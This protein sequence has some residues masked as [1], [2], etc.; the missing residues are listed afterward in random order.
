MS[1]STANPLP[2]P[3]LAA[4]VAAVE[5]S[6]V[7]AAADALD[8]TQSAVTKRLHSLERRVGV[9]LL[10]RG[11]FGARPTVPGRLLYPEAKQ[12]LAALHRAEMIVAE[13]RD[14]AA[15]ALALAAS[16]TIG[17]YLLPGWLAAFRADQPRLRAQVD[18]IN[19]PGVLHAVREG[20]AS[21]G[22]VEGVDSLDGFEAITIHRDEIVVVVAA[23]HPWRRRR[24]ISAAHLRG[25]PYFTREAASGTRAVATA[26]LARAGIE[27]SPALETASTQGIKRALGS[28]GFALLSRLAVAT[29]EE[30]GTLRTLPVRDVDLSREL[31]AV[32]ACGTPL[33]GLARRL[34]VWLEEH[35][36]A[37]ASG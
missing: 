31:R 9:K 32:H 10:E 5:T 29:E 34:W 35:P 3:D 20:D 22:F 28:G 6:S 18:I 4:F 36:A 12:A 2:G 37:R 19:S 17:E 25:E 7:H 26:A 8:L 13:H 1:P 21:I 30:A 14:L 11:R 24:S 33:P 23:D 16:H 15:Q 27:I